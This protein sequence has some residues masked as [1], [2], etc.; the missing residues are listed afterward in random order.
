MIK[1]LSGKNTR[2][3]A[4]V[5]MAAVCLGFSVV[6][7]GTMVLSRTMW[8]AD[9]A[10]FLRAHL[11]LLAIS[12]FIVSVMFLD[13]LTVL[14]GT[15]ALLCALLPFLFL[16][17]T[18]SATVGTPFTVVTA[19]VYVDNPDPADFLSLPSILNADILVLQEMTPLW[20]DALATSGRWSFESSRALDAN[21]DMK[22]LSR[23]PILSTKTISP[24]S[25][26]TGGRFAV[27][28]ELLLGDA[29]LIVYA[30]HPQTPRS[31]RMWR[32]RSA[33]LRDLGEALRS[34]RRNA[35]VVVAG[36]WNTPSW[37]PFFNDMSSLTGYKSTESRWW[38]RPTRF[39][40][41]F[42]SW[43]QLGTPIDRIV[44]S[45]AVGLKSLTTGPTFGSN[46]LPV[47]AKLTIP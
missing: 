33:Y 16:P 2:G 19:N 30:V 43:T 5:I 9:L 24:D 34:E 12:L 46:H 4:I 40:L 47:V 29:T 21:S 15:F 26:D 35:A 28:Y 41:K 13:V 7:L 25:T 31:P 38:P 11:L 27:R 37:S 23:F 8:I 42:E 22:L 44:V 3:V 17:P 36:D 14:S 6:S 32:E 18:A 1:R 45:P 20:Q 39:S 10:N